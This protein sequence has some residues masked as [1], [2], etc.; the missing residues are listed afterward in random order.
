MNIVILTGKFGN[1][2]M[3]AA[4][5]VYEEILDSESNCNVYIVDII[6]YMFPTFNKFIYKIFDFI[7]GK[8]SSIYNFF[9]KASEK[10]PRIPFKKIALYKIEELLNQYD[11]DFIIATMPIC[12]QYI[13][14]YKKVTGSD[15]P[16]CTYIT[17][18]FPHPYWLAGNTDLY[19]V[20]DHKTEEELVSN[21][22]KPKNIL[23]SGIPV[24]QK[25][26]E[27]YIKK[28][29]TEG[30]NVLIM[31]GGLGIIPSISEFI[32]KLNNAKNISIT[33]IA[34]KNKKLINYLK[35]NYPQ[36]NVVGYTNKVD[37]YM[38]KSDLL[39]TKAGGVTTFE[40][41]STQ[42]PLYVIK[43]FLQQ[44]VG[45]AE[46]I[47]HNNIGRVAW[48]DDIDIAEDILNVIKDKRLLNLMKN[49]MV[50]VQQKFNKTSPIKAFYERNDINCC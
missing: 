5:S 33:V 8:H 4:E 19:F 20:G 35:I 43:P 23:V 41:I 15:I 28:D 10:K 16:L 44:E 40:A 26:K 36:V 9:S 34:G 47:E 39:V 14:E 12:P 1:G 45:N 11:V 3:S 17:D 7:V 24:K 6:E 42:T 31:G 30:T 38:K 32:D 18:I 22:V 27:T 46:Y 29:T 49:N 2:H 25:F 50:D 13:S 48:S 37:Q 21:E